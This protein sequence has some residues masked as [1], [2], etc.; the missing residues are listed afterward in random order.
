MAEIKRISARHVY[1]IPEI[2]E[3]FYSRPLSYKL[4]EAIA[5]ANI[6]NMTKPDT[7]SILEVF[8]GKESVHRLFFEA[9]SL[10][11]GLN[12]NYTYT[13]LDSS[14][15]EGISDQVIGVND[16]A[17]ADFGR[18]FDAILAYFY[19]INSVVNYSTGFVTRNHVV[20]SLRNVHKHLNAGGVLIVDSALDGYRT[21]LE[22]V[23]DNF[24]K[25]GSF[26]TKRQVEHLSLLASKLRSLG[27]QVGPWD[28]VY[29]RAEFTSTYDR[30]S[31][32]CVDTYTSIEVYLCGEP[33]LEY[34][35]Q[36]PFCI[37]YFSEPEIVGMLACAGFSQV[38]FWK[39]DYESGQYEQLNPVV[40]LDKRA[41]AS[42][43]MTNVFVATK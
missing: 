22:G 2:Y 26:Q 33:V 39:C 31:C 7:S 29:V 37:N 18:T 9:A 28:E 6:L 34:A 15:V 12:R 35:L 25:N 13:C 41:T 11:T 32:N 14:G 43:R 16:I 42:D 20:D 8:S 19:S 4:N 1:D 36:L 40:S 30:R 17:Y 27:F 5:F 3:V 24:S 10:H 21:S 38:D 23:E